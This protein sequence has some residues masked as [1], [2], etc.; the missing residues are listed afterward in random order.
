ME[1][2]FIFL[3]KMK[4]RDFGLSTIAKTF[5]VM[6]RCMQKPPL[7]RAELTRSL[8]FANVALSFSGQRKS[9]TLKVSPSTANTRPSTA[10]PNDGRLPNP[11][12]KK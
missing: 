10:R 7:V 11:Y 3:R 4:D 1:T 12:G 5:E 8:D 9:E 6:V 2:G